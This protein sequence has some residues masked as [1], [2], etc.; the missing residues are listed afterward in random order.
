MVK[1]FSYGY[2]FLIWL[3]ISHMVHLRFQLELTCDC[4]VRTFPFDQLPS[5][6]RLLKGYA[7]KPVCIQVSVLLDFSLTVKAATLIFISG[8]GSAISSAKK[9]KSGFIYNLVES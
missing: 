2:I 3:Y 5:H 9:G 1:Y 6:V 4:D 7:W 8:R